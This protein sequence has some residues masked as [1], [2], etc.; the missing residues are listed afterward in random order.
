MKWSLQETWFCPTLLEALTWA[1]T[2][3]GEA[4]DACLRQDP[5]WFR[6]CTKAVPTNEEI[7]EEIF[8]FIMMGCIALNLLDVDLMEVAQKKLSKMDER[9]TIREYTETQEATENESAIR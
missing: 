9:R 5:K 2:E 4:L 1:A 3:V 6:N 8:D 7:A